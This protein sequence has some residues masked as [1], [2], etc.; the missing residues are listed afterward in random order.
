MNINVP[1]HHASEPFRW[2]LFLLVVL[3]MG[4]IA[5]AA[6]TLTLRANP[7]HGSLHIPTLRPIGS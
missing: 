2:K 7:P 4:S 1:H 5:T 3:V 6:I